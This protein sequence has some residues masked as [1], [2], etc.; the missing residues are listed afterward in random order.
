MTM[1]LGVTT[2]RPRRVLG[3]AA[4]IGGVAIAAVIGLLIAESFFYTPTEPKA[5][6]NAS[7]TEPL[8]VPEPVTLKFVP[9]PVIETNPKFFFGSGDGSNGYYSESPANDRLSGR[10]SRSS[11]A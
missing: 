10:S 7:L 8:P 11:Y 5:G 2:V 4:T 9:S 6:A 1:S 3:W